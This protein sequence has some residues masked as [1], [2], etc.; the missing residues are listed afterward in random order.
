[1]SLPS[2]PGTLRGG[3]G[4]G[5]GEGNLIALYGSCVWRMGAGGGT[6]WNIS[7]SV[8]ALRACF[9]KPWRCT[10]DR[11]PLKMKLMLLSVQSVSSLCSLFPVCLYSRFPPCLCSLFPPLPQWR[12][13]TNNGHIYTLS[14]S[15]HATLSKIP[16]VSHTQSQNQTLRQ[17]SETK[18]EKQKQIWKGP[19]MCRNLYCTPIGRTRDVSYSL[20]HPYRQD[21]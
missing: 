12:C 21:P 10:C 18:C 13:G 1:M 14:V 5:G 3:G 6:G 2:T 9:V 15:L 11:C 16:F 19:V 20:F 8:V 7:N 4:G 17:A